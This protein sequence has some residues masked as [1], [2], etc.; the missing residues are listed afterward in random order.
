MMGLERAIQWAFPG[1]GLSRLADREAI[2]AY[3]AAK[4][5][6]Q[7]KAKQNHAS[8]DRNIGR[9]GR[10]LRGQARHLEENH[11]LVDGLLTTMVNH[12]IGPNGIGVEPM[13]R[14]YDGKVHTDFA[15]QLL[16]GYAEWSLKPDSTG[17]LSRPESERQICRTWLRDG[18]CFVEQM[19][20][21]IRGFKHPSGTPYSLQILEPDMVPHTLEDDKQNI[22]QGIQRNAW[23]QC[24]FYHVLHDHP[25]DFSTWEMQTRPVPADSMLHIKMVKRWPQGRGVSILASAL[26][27]ISGVQNY[28]ES[29]LMAARIAAMMAFYIKKGDPTT[30]DDQQTAGKRRKFNL[31]PG[32]IFDDLKV[33]EDVG[34]IESKRPSALLQGFRDSMWRAICS[35]AGANF[36]SVMKQYDGTYSAQR[37]ELV[38]SYVNYGVM[39]NTFIAQQC[40]P[41]YRNYV[42]MAILTGV[43]TV[44]ADVDPLTIYQAHYQPPVMPWI[45]PAKEAKGYRELVKGGFAS[46]A[47]IVRMRNRNPEEVKRQRAK[48]VEENRELNLVFD[49]D[50]YHQFY[51]AKKN[52]QN[53]PVSPPQ[54]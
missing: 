18:E 17:E 45:D 51:G 2:R 53:K 12:I 47:E 13:P 32:T 15:R 43:V 25:G 24:T 20:G 38:E 5:S 36:S 22:R 54:K 10:S 52:D 50:A 29:E 14:R 46:E 31:S 6:R 37:Q 35:A 49:T 23:N 7:H 48:E 9:A 11:D 41:T 21:N 28:E 40:R 44:P 30:Y 27:R 26:P 8:G 34:T 1:W 42:R 4:P 3:E 33:G 39:Q 16:A 19:M